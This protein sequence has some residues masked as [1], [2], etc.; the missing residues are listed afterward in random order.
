MILLRAVI[1]SYISW[2][3]SKYS[4]EVEVEVKEFKF[5]RAANGN[6][7]LEVRSLTGLGM[8]RVP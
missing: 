5:N 1:V 3:D 2:Y 6:G 8:M 7:R 4:L